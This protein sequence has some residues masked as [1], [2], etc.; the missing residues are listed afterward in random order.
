[1]K[2]INR[3]HVAAP[4]SVASPKGV[5]GSVSDS[6]TAPRTA[7]VDEEQEAERERERAIIKA[8]LSVA[9][10][11]SHNVFL[12]I[13]SLTF[14]DSVLL[15]DATHSID[16]SEEQREEDT[17]P[18]THDTSTE[19]PLDIAPISLR[20]L[21]AVS[22]HIPHVQTAREQLVGEMEAMLVTGVQELV[23]DHQYD[24][25]PLPTEGCFRTGHCCLLH[26]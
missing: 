12:I 16:Q 13:H 18:E 19:P 10:I 2:L 25:A 15:V 23:G 26:Y 8:A 17:S 20:S 7:L 14:I 1:M 4:P 6:P 24:S 11:C 21:S 5:N 9:E 3:A 22:S